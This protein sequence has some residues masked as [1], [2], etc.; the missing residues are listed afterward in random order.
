MPLSG[1]NRET[2]LVPT[3]LFSLVIALW[4][5]KSS[6]LLDIGFSLVYKES[7]G[8]LVEGATRPNWA[9]TMLPGSGPAWCTLFDPRGSPGLLLMIRSLPF[10]KNLC[11][12]FHQIYFLC[13]LH[14]KY[15]KE[16]LLK[17]MLVLIIFILVLVQ[18]W[19]NINQSDRKS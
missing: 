4:F 5:T 19:Q 1:Q 18:I 13:F 17:T 7:C 14:E 3:P 12:I 6:V 10:H 15:R 16:I 11:G 9:C 2:N 8:R